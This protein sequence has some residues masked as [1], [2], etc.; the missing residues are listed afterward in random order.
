MYR[1]TDDDHYKEKV[2]RKSLLPPGPGALEGIQ[3]VNVL[4]NSR[5]MTGRSLSLDGGRHLKGG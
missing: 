1:D 3:A 5:Y 4:L 2:A